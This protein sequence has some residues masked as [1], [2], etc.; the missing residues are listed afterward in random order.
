MSLALT[1]SC[2]ETIVVARQQTGWCADKH[3]VGLLRTRGALGRPRDFHRRVK[4]G[5]L[6]VSWGRQRLW[7]LTAMT[8]Y[9]SCSPQRLSMVS[10]T[11]QGAL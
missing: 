7:H 6:F 4:R 3:Y 8:K 10:R 1:Y 5:P 11:A 9:A 2:A